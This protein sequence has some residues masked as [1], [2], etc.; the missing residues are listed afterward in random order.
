MGETP[1]FFPISLQNFKKESYVFLRLKC[2]FLSSQ[3]AFWI[4]C[5]LETFI[6]LIKWY[7]LQSIDFYFWKRGNLLF[8][9][10]LPLISFEKFIHQHFLKNKYYFCFL[11]QLSNAKSTYDWFMTVDQLYNKHKLYSFGVDF[12]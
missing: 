9:A 7:I 11:S 8:I 4:I 12:I 2:T 1:L 5:L 6:R 3:N 10:L